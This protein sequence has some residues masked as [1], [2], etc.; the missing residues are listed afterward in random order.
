VP[1]LPP[2]EEQEDGEADPNLAVIAQKADKGNQQVQERAAQMKLNP[3]QD[4]QFRI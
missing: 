4:G 3:V 1:P 2:E